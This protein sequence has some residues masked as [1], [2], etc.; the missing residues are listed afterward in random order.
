MGTEMKSPPGNGQYCFWIHGQTYRLASSL[1][2]NEANKSGYGQLYIYDSAETTT[3]WSE[4]QY[5]QRCMAEVMQQFDKMLHKLTHLLSHQI[6]HATPMMN[7]CMVLMEDLD[8]DNRQYNA[9][10]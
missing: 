3:E 4:N 8:S 9:P 10:T 1:Y 5:N 7:A 2:P 6:T